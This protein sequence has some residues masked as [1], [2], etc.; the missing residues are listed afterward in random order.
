MP[1]D[2]HDLG[3]IFCQW[4]PDKAGRKSGCGAGRPAFLQE[5][6][7]SASNS[8]PSHENEQVILLLFYNHISV[9]VSV[10]HKLKGTLFPK[11]LDCL[12]WLVQVLQTQ[13]QVLW[14][15]PSLQFHEVLDHILPPH[16]SLRSSCSWSLKMI[17]WLWRGSSTTISTATCEAI[18][19]DWSLLPNESHGG[20]F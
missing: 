11:E 9:L 14:T 1:T 3:F 6:K 15:T 20:K 2:I 5:M 13:V 7:T 10:T 18:H 16:P 19:T 4:S 12:P 8:T 17:R